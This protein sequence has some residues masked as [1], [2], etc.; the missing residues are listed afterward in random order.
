[1][2]KLKFQYFGHMIRRTDSI[3]KSLMLGTIE[4]RRRR[5]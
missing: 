4:D 3:E 5:G 1:M 2:I